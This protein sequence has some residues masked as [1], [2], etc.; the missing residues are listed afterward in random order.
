M[1]KIRVF[2]RNLGNLHVSIAVGILT[3]A[4]REDPG[5]Y[6]AYKANIAMAFYDE[7]QRRNE[8]KTIKKIDWHELSNVAAE[9]F[10]QLWTKTKGG[11]WK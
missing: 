2:F 6:I 3:K 5:F 1:D 8:Y 10:M 7:V 11:K 9:N 4:L